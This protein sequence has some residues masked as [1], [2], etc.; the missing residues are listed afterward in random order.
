M[1]EIHQVLPALSYGDAASNHAIELRGILRGWGYSSNIY[2]KYIHPKVSRFANPLEA[3]KENAAN[4]VIY[5]LSL[6]GLD[7]SEFVQQLPDTKVLIYH[8]VTPH[9]YFEGIDDTLYDLCKRGREELKQ[10]TRITNLALG[11]SEYSRRELE[12]YGFKDT[13]VL[14]II[15]DYT[16]YAIE[17]D[18]K[19]MGTYANSS[20]ANLLFV[21][22]IAPNKRIEDLIEIFYYYKKINSKG[23]LFFY[24]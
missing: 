16:K 4:I 22:R 3:Y 15:L 8:N 5:H 23:R 10:F 17:P 2:A 13:G 24:A 12:Q 6:A 21:G 14:P 7:V 9:H 19:I 11:V 18:E 1:P 20:Y